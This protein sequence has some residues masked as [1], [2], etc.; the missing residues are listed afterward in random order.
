MPLDG[1]KGFAKGNVNVSIGI[2][3]FKNMIKKENYYGTN[4]IGEIEYLPANLLSVGARTKPSLLSIENQPAT[5]IIENNFYVRYYPI[6]FSCYKVA[7]FGEVLVMG[8]NAKH[9]I[10][11][12]PLSVKPVYMGVATGLVILFKSNLKAQ[13][14]NDFFLKRANR[15]SL[16]LLWNFKSIPLKNKE[17]Q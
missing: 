15:G 3:G 9:T 1:Y 11:G 4:L 12:E 6:A 7:F 17:A 2:G 10:K 14:S 8:D 13:V 16:S 5:V